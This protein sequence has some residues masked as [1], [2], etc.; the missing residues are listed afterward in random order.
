MQRLNTVRNKLLL[1][2][3]AITAAA[4]GFVYLYVVPQL[5]SNLTAQ[6]ISRL[7]EQGSR[8]R[9]RLAEAMGEGL[10]PRSLAS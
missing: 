9:E 3:F 4:I 6:K 7:Q 10:P 8:E 5:E 2:F 1:L